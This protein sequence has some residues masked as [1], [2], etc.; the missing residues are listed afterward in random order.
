MKIVMPCCATKNDIKWV[1]NGREI[2]F[3]AHPELEPTQ[4]SKLYC[5]PDDKI[6][7]DRSHRQK[8]LLEGYGVEKLVWTQFNLVILVVLSL[9]F[10][11]IFLTLIIVKKS[12]KNTS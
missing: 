3:I 12:M 5:K 7:D 2:K 1:L 11:S 4:S 8:I 10:I 6:I 9:I